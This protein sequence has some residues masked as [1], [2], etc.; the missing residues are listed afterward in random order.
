MAQ[1]RHYRTVFLGGGNAAGYFASEAVAQGLPPGDLAII[2]AEAA[3][4]YERPAL[5]KAYLAPSAPARLPG[6]HACVGGGGSRQEPA[7]Y[8]EH[9]IAYLTQARVTA[10]DLAS[11]TLT[12]E[13]GS[14]QH[15]GPVAF[16]RLVVGTGARPVDLDADA[17]VPG[18][19]LGGIHYLRSV[20]DADALVA[21]IAHAK[22]A[23]LPVVV[24]GGGYIGAETAAGLAGWGLAGGVTV[25]FPEPHLMA[26]IL[27]PAAASFYE[28]FYGAKGV[29]LRQGVSVAGFDEDGGQTGRVG[30][31]RLSDGTSLPAGLVVVGVGARPVTDLLASAGAAVLAGPPGGLAVDAALRSTSHPGLVW[32]VG[33]VAAFP[34][35]CAVGSAD[36]DARLRLEHVNHA[37]ASAAHVA[38]A[39]YGSGGG[40][41]EA[42]P[43]AHTPHFY[44]R[45]FNLSWVAFGSVGPAPGVEAVDFGGATAAAGAAA[46]A[47]DGGGASPP[48]F[49]TFW[50]RGRTTVV[51]AFLEGGSPDDVA[52]LKACVEAQPAAPA[53]LAAQGLAFARAVVAKL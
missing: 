4:S 13:G 2:T 14:P 32:A 36:P 9:G 44:S 48:T 37:R 26:R 7:W 23:S 49:G 19:G 33:D 39:L 34:G 38:R 30:G 27:S 20:A 1:A 24:V 8:A 22:A 6:F 16:D 43:Y 21:A 46:A 40:G 18:A 51:G 25:V 35:A 10:V 50:V 15:A 17:H 47:A 12:I 11:R 41:D 52:A 3:V 42:K 53:D 28:G 5:S 31:V 45:V 29:T